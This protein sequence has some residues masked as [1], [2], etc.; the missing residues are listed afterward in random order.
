VSVGD[1]EWTGELDQAAER[2]DAA[3]RRNRVAEDCD[4]QRAAA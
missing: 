1:A 3:T 4:Q 2:D